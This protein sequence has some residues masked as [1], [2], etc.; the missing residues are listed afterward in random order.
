MPVG[1]QRLTL[2]IHLDAEG[3]L[4]VKG[5]VT[6]GQPR[7]MVIHAGTPTLTVEPT[8]LHDMTTG[9]IVIAPSTHPARP[10]SGP[11]GTAAR[12]GLLQRLFR[13]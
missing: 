7:K 2:A 10:S 1:V 13:R 8:A 6:G 11:Q 5:H 9:T 12:T 3:I 4:D